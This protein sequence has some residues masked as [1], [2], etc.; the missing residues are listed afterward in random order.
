M[1]DT[2]GD[3]AIGPPEAC[4]ASRPLAVDRAEHDQRPGAGASPPLQAVS[5]A[6]SRLN[7]PP[8]RVVGAVSLAAP[9]ALRDERGW[10][11][12]WIGIGI[13]SY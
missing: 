11:R 7:P 12:A 10:G 4:E 9:S 1:R 2:L 6:L 8:R 13:R 3:L 5:L